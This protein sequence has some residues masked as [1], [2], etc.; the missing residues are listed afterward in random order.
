MGHE[1]CR[2]AYPRLEQEL[3]R[4]TAIITRTTY[5][6]NGRQVEKGDGVEGVSALG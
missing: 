6:P 1:A 3:S 4:P 5:V 2:T